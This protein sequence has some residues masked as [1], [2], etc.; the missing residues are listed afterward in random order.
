MWTGVAELAELLDVVTAGYPFEP[1]LEERAPDVMTRRAHFKDVVITLRAIPGSRAYGA[2]ELQYR[3]GFDDD[4]EELLW[5][6]EL[7][8][9]QRARQGQATRWRSYLQRTCSLERLVEHGLTEAVRTPRGPDLAGGDDPFLTGLDG[10]VEGLG[11]APGDHWVEIYLHAQW[12][13]GRVVSTDWLANVD[14]ELAKQSL[15]LPAEDRVHLSRMLWRVG[16]AYLEHNGLKAAGETEP[17]LDGHPMPRWIK[18][19]DPGTTVH[20]RFLKQALAGCAVVRA[21]FQ[22][23]PQQAVALIDHDETQCA[24]TLTVEGDVVTVKFAAMLKQGW[25][26][27]DLAPSFDYEETVP[28]EDLSDS[29]QAEELG[30][31]LRAMDQA[32]SSWAAVSKSAEAEMSGK[33]SLFRRGRYSRSSW[34]YFYTLAQALSGRKVTPR[35]L[36]NVETRFVGWMA[37]AAGPEGSQRRELAAAHASLAVASAGI[38]A[39]AAQQ[40]VI[41]TYRPHAFADR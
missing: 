40:G 17:D 32:W 22:P 34:P 21:H 41:P 39:I 36:N 11:G 28:L 27:R 31:R 7:A 19:V 16:A 2:P 8:Q 24:V 37:T 3:F 35:W 23:W 25:I 38:T 1:V 26:G 6:E 10:F 18:K 9:D 33:T 30:R 4:G 15:N 14:G 20:R 12:L 5:D 13:L 29:H